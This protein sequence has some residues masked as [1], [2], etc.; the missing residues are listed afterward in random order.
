MKSYNDFLNEAYLNRT[1]PIKRLL[2]N[3][4][5]SAVNDGNLRRTEV[6]LKLGADVHTGR[7]NFEERNQALDYAVNNNDLD[8]V[9]L[10]G[11]HGI[12]LDSYAMSIME[13]SC[14]KG[15]MEMFLYFVDLQKNLYDSVHYLKISNKHKKYEISEYIIDW[16]LKY[17]PKKINKI[18]KLIPDELK[19][20]Y[21][22]ILAGS[23]HGLI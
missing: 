21:A 14:K 10:L 12:D 18:I 20:K 2:N 17:H 1:N 13:I 6:L 19:S 8:M 9:H 22:H 16:I 11:K 5:L 4:F 23:D 3:K 15:Y 7:V